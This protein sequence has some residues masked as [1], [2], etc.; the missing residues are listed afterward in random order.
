MELSDMA[1][2]V[3]FDNLRYA[4]DFL[5]RF[6]PETYKTIWE[7]TENSFTEI[8]MYITINL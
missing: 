1:V 4:A 8:N 6:L 5:N 2:I 7:S 3:M